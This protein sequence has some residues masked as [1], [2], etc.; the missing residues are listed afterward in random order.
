MINKSKNLIIFKKYQSSPNYDPI[1]SG[2]V[3]Y[4]PS[5]DTIN[6]HSDISNVNLKHDLSN[7]YLMDFSV[8]M[9]QSLIFQYD[10]TID[11]SENILKNLF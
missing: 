5:Y 7:H 1:T 11:T 3:S 10:Y 2:V 9:Y 4:V 8:N 6:V